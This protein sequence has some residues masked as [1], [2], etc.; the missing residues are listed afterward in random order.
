MAGTD[1]KNERGNSV[2][3]MMRGQVT[4]REISYVGA[5]HGT[6]ITYT[7]DNANTKLASV[8]KINLRGLMGVVPVEIKDSQE[9]AG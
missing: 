2:R 9:A 1:W 7:A 4:A 8:A 6:S 5:G 3:P